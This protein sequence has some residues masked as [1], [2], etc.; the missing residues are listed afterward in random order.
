MTLVLSP[1]SF[2]SSL[3]SAVVNIKPSQ[4]VA[5]CTSIWE[6]ISP[7]E[8]ISLHPYL[9]VHKI[10]YVGR[11]HGITGGK[12]GGKRDGK[13]ERESSSLFMYPGL[14]LFKR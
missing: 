10:S 13:Q 4:P 3:S 8:G 9:R 12:R 1:L 14:T 5:A 2:P 7:R 6:C 11:F